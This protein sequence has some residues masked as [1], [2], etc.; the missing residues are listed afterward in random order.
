[1]K[2]IILLGAPGAGKGTA[3]ERIRDAAGFMHVSTGDMLREAVKQSTIL[4]G[5]AEGYMHRG[6][7]VPDKIIM[8]L[9]EGVLKDAPS[10]SEFMFDGFPRTIGQADLLDEVLAKR[11]TKLEHVIFLDAPQRVLMQRLTGRRI[12]RACGAN[13]HINNL[14]PRQPGIC[15][16]CGGELYQRPDDSEATI[17]SRLQVYSQ[18]TEGLIARYTQRGVLRR[19]DSSCG[20]DQL[21]AEVL[22]V[23]KAAGAAD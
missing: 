7:L 10:H 16:R 12:C 3:A 14:P 4:G 19:V 22:S 20:A 9:V 11:G 6:E 21:A 15:D 2:A 8:R 5:E 17:A 13:F 23:L 18:M 1:M